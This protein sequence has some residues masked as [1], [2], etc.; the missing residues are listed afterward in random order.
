M[1]AQGTE[2]LRETSMAIL[3][4]FGFY[5]A[6]GKVVLQVIA[7]LKTNLQGAAI[8][9]WCATRPLLSIIGGVYCEDAGIAVLSLKP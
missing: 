3:Q 6:Q 9:V 4:Q 2:L 7:S 1:L 8:V 5:D